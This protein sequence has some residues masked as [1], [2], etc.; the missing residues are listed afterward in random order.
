MADRRT[1]REILVLLRDQGEVFFWEFPWKQDRT[2]LRSLDVLSAR[3]VVEQGNTVKPV[4][5]QDLPSTYSY[6]LTVS[7][8]SAAAKLTSS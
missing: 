5:T 6:R 2:L 1:Q 4:P 3:G 8:Q 7:G